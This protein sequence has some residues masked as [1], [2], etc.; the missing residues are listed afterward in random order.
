MSIFS[1]TIAM[2]GGKPH[3]Q[4]SPKKYVLAISHCLHTFPILYQFID[5]CSNNPQ[6]QKCR[7]DEI[8]TFLPLPFPVFDACVKRKNTF[9]DLEITIWIINPAISATKQNPIPRSRQQHPDCVPKYI[10]YSPNIYIYTYPNKNHGFR[11]FPGGLDFFFGCLGR[12]PRPCQ[13]VQKAL[14]TKAVQLVAHL[15]ISSWECFKMEIPIVMDVHSRYIYIYNPRV[16]PGG[17]M[18]PLKK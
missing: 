8:P 12:R 13:W 14:G 7:N 4:T 2:T 10:Q 5:V 11:V 1:T 18:G 6:S 15:A 9:F 16:V 17:G 3:V